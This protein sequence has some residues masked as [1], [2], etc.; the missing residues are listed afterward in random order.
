M[1]SK[2][3]LKNAYIMAIVLFVVGFLCY[4]AFPAKPPENPV[5][6]MMTS[7]A[8]NIVFNHKIHTS[9]DGYALSCTDCHHESE[10]GEEVQACGDCHEKEPDEDDDTAPIKRSD[11][12]HAQCAGCHEDFGAG[13][14]NVDEDCNKCHVL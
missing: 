7:A 1:V 14:L 13:P 6:L 3:N 10:E 11:A 5:R 2:K 12:F 9:S 8:G 4:A